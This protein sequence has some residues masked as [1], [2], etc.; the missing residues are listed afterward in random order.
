MKGR[1]ESPADQ[2]AE[3]EGKPDSQKHEDEA[4]AEEN[5]GREKC[6]PTGCS[7]AMT[8]STP[9]TLAY[10]VSE[11]ATPLT[12]TT[13]TVPVA[14]MTF[15]GGGMDGE[16]LEASTRVLSGMGDEH[17]GA[18]DKVSDFL[19]ADGNIVHEIPNASQL[20]LG[21]QPAPFPPHATRRGGYDHEGCEVGVILTGEAIVVSARIARMT[22][23]VRFEADV[24]SMRLSLRMAPF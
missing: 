12:V 22:S 2:E 19:S 20:Q 13:V 21:D 6:F 14:G 23:L 9:S 1:E 17:A 15:G 7:T 18:G 24:G 3:H 10:A 16:S 4:L 8:Q 5:A 11:W